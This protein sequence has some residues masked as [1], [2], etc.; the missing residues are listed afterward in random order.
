MKQCS[1]GWLWKKWNFW[2]LGDKNVDRIE[3]WIDSLWQNWNKI[4]ELKKKIDN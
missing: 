3:W 4:V 1:D 2:W